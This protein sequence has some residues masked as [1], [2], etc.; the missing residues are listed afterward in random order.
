MS[1]RVDGVPVHFPNGKKATGLL[2]YS[3]KGTMSAQI[4]DPQRIKCK[5]SD[6]RYPTANELEN[7]YTQFISYFGNYQIYPDKNLIVHD[8]EMSLFPNWIGTKVKRY[9]S[10][11]DNYLKLT[12]KA[13]PIKYEGRLS[14]PV[15]LWEKL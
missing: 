7:N 2:T 14:E 10:F 6:Y 15:L 1:L 3:A 11:S 12:L 13:T 5:S 4:G 9:F 8:I